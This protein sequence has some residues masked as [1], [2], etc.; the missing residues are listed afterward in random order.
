M[1]WYI[2]RH[3]EKE[4]G[5]FFNHALRHQD[6]P[7]S[8]RGLVESQRLWEYFSDK[9][10]NRLYISQYKRTGQTAEYVAKKLGFKPVVDSTLE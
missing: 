6:E 9:K 4:R 10:V 2:L 1:K 3:A 7:I 8:S 5:N